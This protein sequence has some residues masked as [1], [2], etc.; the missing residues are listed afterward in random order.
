MATWTLDD[1]CWDRFDGTK[2]SDAVIRAVKAAALVEYNSADYVTYLRKVFHDDPAFVAAAETWGEEEAQHGRALGRWA[3]MADPAFDFEAAFAAFREGYRIPVDAT[4]SVRGSRSGEL[5]ARC[6]VESGTSSYYTAMK[7][8]TQEPVL[9]Q[10]AAHIAADE[11]RHYKLFY[12]H[13]QRYRAAERP[14]LL[15]RLGVALGRIRE[16]EDDELAYAYHCANI[17]ADRPYDRAHCASAYEE[18]ALSLYERRHTDRLISMSMKAV[19]LDPHGRTAG[20]LG[21]VTWNGL[22]LKQGWKQKRAA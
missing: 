9:R 17:G 16:A 7:E 10:I 20:L 18:V 19:G 11:F 12:E 15:R 14:M 2:V 4:E 8:R 3:E 6:V 1:I 21:A 5:I 22:R 13:L